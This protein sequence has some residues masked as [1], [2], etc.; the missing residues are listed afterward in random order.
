[1]ALSTMIV[2]STL[3]GTGIAFGGYGAGLR[4]SVAIALGCFTAAGSV[5][6]HSLGG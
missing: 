6:I 2:S 5:L 1:M 4:V 3:I